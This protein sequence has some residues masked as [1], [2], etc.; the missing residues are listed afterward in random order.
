M[1][2]SRLEWALPG[3]VGPAAA[4]LAQQLLPAAL[5]KRS[6]AAVA[7]QLLPAVLAQLGA[8]PSLRAR[9]EKVTALLLAAGPL[10]W[11]LRWF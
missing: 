2:G 6:Q 9:K 1:H 7:S 5:A 10:R 11:G 4:L 3:A 8:N